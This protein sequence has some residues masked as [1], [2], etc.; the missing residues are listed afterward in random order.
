MTIA[1]LRGAM[2]VGR[3]I[4]LVLR[5]FPG[6]R[7][8]PEGQTFP[9]VVSQH[10]RLAGHC[11]R[12]RSRQRGASPSFLDKGRVVSRPRLCF[13]AVAQERSGKGARCRAISTRAL[14]S[15]P[16]CR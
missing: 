13:Q 3:Y 1:Q 15:F 14:A 9:T 2:A 12:M 4:T 10:G 5:S 11:C 8:E 16:L 7:P 6:Q